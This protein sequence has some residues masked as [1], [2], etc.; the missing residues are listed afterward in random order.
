MFV[1]DILVTSC[2]LIGIRGGGD[3]RPHTSFESFAIGLSLLLV[4]QRLDDFQEVVGLKR[5]FKERFD[6]HVRKWFSS[7]LSAGLINEMIKVS[8]RCSSLFTS[9]QNPEKVIL[10]RW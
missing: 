1:R 10:S 4:L 8:V 5:L 3:R 9:L 6:P 2:F 7:G